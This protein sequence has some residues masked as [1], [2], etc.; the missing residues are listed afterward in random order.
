MMPWNS[1]SSGHGACNA[2]ALRFLHGAQVLFQCRDQPFAIRRQ[3]FSQGRRLQNFAEAAD[4]QHIL[5][6]HA[7]YVGAAL[8][9]NVDQAVRFQP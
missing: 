4:L 8:R 2:R 5:A 7:E 9:M 1:A 3:R 6:A